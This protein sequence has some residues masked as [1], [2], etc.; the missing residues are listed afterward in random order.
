MIIAREQVLN[1]IKNLPEQI[2][3]EDL[4]KLLSGS[5]RMDRM[6]MFISYDSHSDSELA[7]KLEEWLRKTFDLEVFLSERSLTPGDLWREKI[8]D[9]AKENNIILLLLGPDSTTPW[10]P[11][12]AGLAIGASK[13]YNSC[14]IVPIVFGGVRIKEVSRSLS[15]FSSRI[16]YNGRK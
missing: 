9:A 14:K 11:F 12:E 3:I 6:K 8:I 16:W 5:T 15:D 13:N 1:M 7:K 4:R 2:D 10:I